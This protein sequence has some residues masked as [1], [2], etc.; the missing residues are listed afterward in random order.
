MLNWI[1]IILN[2]ST[3]LLL[4]LYIS[5][6]CIRSWSKEADIFCIDHLK[7]AF[8]ISNSLLI[9]CMIRI[10]IGL[11]FIEI[12]FLFIYIYYDLIE[13]SLFISFLMFASNFLIWY[14]MSNDLVRGPMPSNI[15]MKGKTVIVTGANTGI[16]YHITKILAS[17][18][19]KFYCTEN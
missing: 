5:I 8:I 2:G 7:Y 11:M 18:G 12:F 15:N 14:K 4:I 10:Y 6:L 13:E 19:K 9:Q 3:F 16:G 1:F 17:Y